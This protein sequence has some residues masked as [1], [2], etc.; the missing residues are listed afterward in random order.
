MWGLTHQ[1]GVCMYLKKRL[2]LATALLLGAGPATAPVTAASASDGRG[3]GGAPNKVSSA[4][5][6][7]WDVY[8]RGYFVKDIPA[9]KINVIQYAFGVPSFD[10]AT[11]AVSC[12]VLDP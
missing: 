12:N 4:Y 11:G 9:D 1:R 6:A 10:Q 8:G 3:S 7:D 2:A 5:F